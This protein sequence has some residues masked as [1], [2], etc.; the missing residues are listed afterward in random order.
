M[1]PRLNAKKGG[2]EVQLKARI[3]R[4]LV[5][6]QLKYVDL[7]VAIEMNLAGISLIEEV[8]GHHDALLIAGKKQVMRRR[9]RAK[10]NRRYKARVGSVGDVEQGHDTGSGT[11]SGIGAD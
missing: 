11:G 1:W 7:V 9:T 2:A 8:I 3:H 6:F 4:Q 5:I 10:V